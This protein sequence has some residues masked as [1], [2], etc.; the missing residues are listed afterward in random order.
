LSIADWVF[1]A[2]TAGIAAA[3]I[4]VEATIV[5]WWERAGFGAG[6]FGAGV[7][8]VLFGLGLYFAGLVVFWILGVLATWLFGTAQ[9]LAA[10]VR[11]CRP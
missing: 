8:V 6:E 9:G 2:W 10:S 11:S 1:A 3:V 4:L 5:L 7:F